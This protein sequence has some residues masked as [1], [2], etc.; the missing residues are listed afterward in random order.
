MQ[1]A[2]SQDFTQEPIEA[3]ES[4]HPFRL[5]I[6]AEVVAYAVLIVISLLL[7][8]AELDSVPISGPETHQALAAWRVA[9]PQAPGDPLIASSPVVFWLQ[10][11]GF[12]LMA[13]TN[14]IIDRFSMSSIWPMLDQMLS[15]QLPV[16]VSRS[17]KSLM[18]IS[19]ND[20]FN[21]R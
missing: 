21:F 9:N 1:E 18:I 4:A 17:L 3:T 20:R 19:S 12:S 11:W 14:R 6:S 8:V 16:K 10:T 7:R 5:T 13:S 15:I 2:I